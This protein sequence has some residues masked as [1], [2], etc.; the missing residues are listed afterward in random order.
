MGRVET[1]L[2][3]ILSFWLGDEGLKLGGREGVNQSGFGHDEQE[4]LSS[5]QGRKFVGLSEGRVS[6]Q[7]AR[8]K[9]SNANVPSS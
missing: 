7:S 5:S 4:Y 3:E 9:L 2:D 8:G 6:A 1:S